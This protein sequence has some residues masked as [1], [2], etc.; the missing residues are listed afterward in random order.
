MPVFRPDETLDE[1][2]PADQTNFWRLQRHEGMECLAA[3]FRTHEFPPHSH[4][5]FVVGAVTGGVNAYR[6]NGVKVHAGKGQLCFVNP[7][8]VHNTILERDGYSYRMTYPAGNFLRKLIERETE[9]PS[10][11]PRFRSPI[12]DDPELSD[13]FLKAHVMLEGQGDELEADEAFLSA[14]T[15]MLHRHADGPSPRAAG[16]EPKAVQHAC[17]ILSTCLEQPPELGALAVAVGLSPFHLI[18]VFRKATGLTPSAWVA[19]RRVHLAC[20]LLRC[21]ENATRVAAT[22][23]FFDQSHFSRTFKSRLGVTPG[24]FMKATAA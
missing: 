22:C 11:M 4:E 6:I 5:C 10:P 21:G 20:R 1:T 19:D 7:G 24:E 16:Q 14:Y 9:R 13:A 2:S 12:V 15:N 18:R 23:G 17:E 8:E 3:R